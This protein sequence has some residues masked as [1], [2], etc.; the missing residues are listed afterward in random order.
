MVMVL[1][2]GQTQTFQMIL[3]LVIYWG[4]MK[5]RLMSQQ[6]V[7]DTTKSLQLVEQPE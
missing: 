7:L 4:F 1:L 3:L 2:L 5:G 6:D